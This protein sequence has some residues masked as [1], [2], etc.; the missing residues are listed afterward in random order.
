M[1]DNVRKLILLPRYTTYAGAR[2]YLT[3]PFWIH[4]F[5]RADL[6]AF[7]GAMIGSSATVSIQIQESPDLDLWIDNGSAFTS[8]G[9][10]IGS[11]EL[12]HD[13]MRVAVTLAGTDPAVSLWLVGNFVERAKAARAGAR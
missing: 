13:W 3:Q 5:A 7:I 4:D 6:M 2:T 10:A 12:A 8:A 1:S 9:E 11:F